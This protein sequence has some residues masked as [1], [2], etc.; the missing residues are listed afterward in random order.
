M[1]CF[2]AVELPPEAKALLSRVQHDAMNLGVNASF[3]D[4]RGLHCTLAFLGEKSDDEVRQTMAQLQQVRHNKFAAQVA[5]LGFF[6]SPAFGRVFWAGFESPGLT[7][8]QKKI[9]EALA[10]AED[11][12]F[13]P[14]VTLARIRSKTNLPGLA[15]Y[16]Q[17]QAL[18]SS[19]F[20]VAE[21]VLKKS[22]LSP[23][24]AIHETIAKFALV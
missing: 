17:K 22:V 15:S 1:R 7:E 9:V 6:P 8:L 21:F 24:G 16:A 2:V 19:P 4:G 11:K 3:P 14:H 18:S 23:T 20:T 12:P 5:G 10:L 13:A